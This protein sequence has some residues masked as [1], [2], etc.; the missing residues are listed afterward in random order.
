MAHITSALT[1]QRP[2]V[3]FGWAVFTLC[4]QSGAAFGATC[5]EQ[6]KQGAVGQPLPVSG[7]SLCIF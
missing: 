4:V 7:A 2:E 3:L 1:M 5:V 6:R